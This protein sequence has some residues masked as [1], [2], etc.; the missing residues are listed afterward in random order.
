MAVDDLKPIVLEFDRLL[1]TTSI[2][3][4][5]ALIPVKAVLSADAR[6]IALFL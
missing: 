6:P 1:P 3:D 4:C 2:V 5:E